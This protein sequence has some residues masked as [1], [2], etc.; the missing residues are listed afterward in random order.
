[1][2]KSNNK[3]LYFIVGFVVLVVLVAIY[4]AICIYCFLKKKRRQQQQKNKSADPYDPERHKSLT[5]LKKDGKKS[6]NKREK[7]KAQETPTKTGTKVTPCPSG[8][9]H[10]V[11]VPMTID[12]IMTVAAGK[13][14]QTAK[15]IDTKPPLVDE[16]PIS[17]EIK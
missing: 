14:M 13:K 10:G 3:I 8:V 5:T 6:Y 2:A 9:A 1:M 7:I 15:P 4:V 17:V 12:S 11:A 16:A